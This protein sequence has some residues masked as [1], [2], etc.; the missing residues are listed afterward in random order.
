[1]KHDVL[2]PVDLHACRPAF[3]NPRI[4]KAYSAQL[5]TVKLTDPE[6]D[7]STIPDGAINEARLGVYLHWS[8]PRGYRS[9]VSS[10]AGAERNDPDDPALKTGADPKLVPKNI[11]PPANPKFRLVPNRWLVVR[12]LKEQ[13]PPEANL[14]ILDA[15]VIESDR[16]RTVEALEALPDEIVRTS[17]R[18]LL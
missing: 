9:G 6:P 18:F 15:W 4:S 13:R 11:A 10:A 8:L 12:K 5:Q 2:P 17:F 1:V 16:L 7:F 3:L 14:P